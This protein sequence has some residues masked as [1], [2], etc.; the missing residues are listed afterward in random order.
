MRSSH[1]SSVLKKGGIAV[2]PTDTI[3]GI[4]ARARSP[5]AV[6]RLYRLR[7]KTP[8]KPFI[9]LIDS[10][11]SVQD[12]G[13]RLTSTQK[14]FL[15]RVW[16]GKVSVIFPCPAKQFSYLHLKTKTL[17]LRLPRSLEQMEWTKKFLAGC[18]P[19]L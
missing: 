17:A 19:A 16:P 9:I 13:I 10:I 2:I 14:I 12:L 3:Y 11:A 1:L 5:R 18:L 4:I 6:A 8:K 15:E 7:R